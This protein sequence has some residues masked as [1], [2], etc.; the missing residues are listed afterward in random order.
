MKVT[1]KELAKKAG[2]STATVSMI[3][4]QKDQ[5][6][7]EATR[8]KVRALA[9]EYQY[10]PNTNARSLVTRKTKTIGLIMPDITNP[11]F[12]EMARGVEDRASKSRYSIILC[13]TDD[14]EVREH[15]CVKILA[16]KMVDGII[17]T[18]CAQRDEPSADF[19]TF[20]LPI[21]LIDRDAY[22]LDNIKGRVTIDNEQGAFLAVDH[23]IQCGCRHIL[24]LSGEL[25]TQTAKERLAGYRRAL[26]AYGL[27]FE[28]SN[29]RAGAYKLEWGRQAVD[30]VMEE[31]KEFDGVFC[32]NDLIGIGAIKR[33]QEWGIQ[34]PQDVR[35]IGFDDIYMASLMEPPMSTV[36][37]PAYEMGYRAAELLIEAIEQKQDQ[38]PSD[39]SRVVLKPQLMI[40]RSTE[41]KEM[42]KRGVKA[43]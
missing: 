17:F 16:E 26:S 3:L 36:R 35:L 28:E 41:I 34:I 6:I 43:Q 8:S 7:S 20:E 5:S 22:S 11:F 25:C 42:K 4:N 33:L 13:D 14:N 1:L 2:V 24:F 38:I 30:Q 40:R 18:H 23:L 31:K 10:V 19:N 39:E 21:I 12:P 9:K 29:V 32:G 37:Q 27:A 15:Q